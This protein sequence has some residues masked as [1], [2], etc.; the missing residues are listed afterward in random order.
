MLW[1][2]KFIER[3][4]DTSRRAALD[5][6][7]FGRSPTCDRLFRRGAGGLV[8]L[9]GR[10]IDP[11]PALRMNC[12][13]FR[14]LCSIY[15]LIL[16]VI[17]TYIIYIPSIAEAN[18]SRV[19]VAPPIEDMSARLKIVK[20]GD[21]FYD[22]K[23]YFVCIR[24]LKG[25]FYLWEPLNDALEKVNNLKCEIHGKTLIS[26]NTLVFSTLSDDNSVQNKIGGLKGNL[27]LSVSGF[28]GATSIISKNESDSTN[29]APILNNYFEIRYP[30]GASAS[31]YVVTRLSK[32]QRWTILSTCEAGNGKTSSFEQKY[33]VVSILSAIDIGNGYTLLQFPSDDGSPIFIRLKA[34][35]E[36]V[37]GNGH[38]FI[39]R[40]EPIL[41]DLE[42][43][44]E[45]ENA[46]DADRYDVLL[47]VIK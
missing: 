1:R 39:V 19:M 6:A 44:S 25:A 27:S 29:C 2:F 23:N 18:T 3:K 13:V 17:I 8:S 16:T 10:Y 36:K 45:N 7:V 46:S 37:W 47:S 38:A 31:F 15:I 24:T 12:A 20:Y 5:G 43:A 32:P 26:V 34:L 14:I 33:G 4:S 40:R 22:G 42:R 30:S 11:Y 9:K 41:T 21:T 35:P 28:S